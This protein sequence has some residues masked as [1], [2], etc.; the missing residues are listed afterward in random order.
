MDTI[1]CDN[2]EGFY[3]SIKTI[4]FCEDTQILLVKGNNTIASFII[5]CND[6]IVHLKART[7]KK[8]FVVEGKD[9][10][11]GGSIPIDEIINWFETKIF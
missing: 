2:K 11:K 6:S 9:R 3:F 1:K 10:E 7:E 8:S 5:I 4:V